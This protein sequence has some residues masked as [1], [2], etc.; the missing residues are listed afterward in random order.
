MSPAAH[1][2]SAPSS[3]SSTGLQLDAVIAEQHGR[4]T[5]AEDRVMLDTTQEAGAP[6]RGPL[7][8]IRRHH[9][10]AS[11]GTCVTEDDRHATKARPR[12][13]SAPQGDH[14]QSISMRGAGLRFKRLGGR[15]P[16]A[17]RLERVVTVTCHC[18]AHSACEVGLSATPPC[19]VRLPT[20][21]P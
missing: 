7:P 13:P 20:P 10:V 12:R 5:R 21:H 15:D 17:P 16:A 18:M 19:C 3:S 11:R 9:N 2:S 1:A 4:L 8:V 6:R 14:N